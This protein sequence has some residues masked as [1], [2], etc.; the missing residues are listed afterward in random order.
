MPRVPHSRDI[1]RQAARELANMLYQDHLQKIKR[2][3]EAEKRKVIEQSLKNLNTWGWVECPYSE[4]KGQGF[5]QV[6]PSK[7]EIQVI[8]GSMFWIGVCPNGKKVYVN[9][10]VKKFQ[11]PDGSILWMPDVIYMNEDDF[12]IWFNGEGNENAK[13]N[14]NINP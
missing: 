14:K 6:D 8:K 2:S 7:S 11:E 1:E 9:I 12:R 5:I 3:E 10:F 4:Y 13:R